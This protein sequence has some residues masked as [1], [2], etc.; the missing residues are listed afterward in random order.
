MRRWWAE[1]EDPS[2]ECAV[3]L[4]GSINHTVMLDDRII[5]FAQWYEDSDPT[6]R[7]AGLG[8][9]AVPFGDS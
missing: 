8:L 5:G 2:D 7:H 6:F 3:N 1:W 9:T 4:T